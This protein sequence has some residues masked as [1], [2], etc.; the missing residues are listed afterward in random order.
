MSFTLCTPGGLERTQEASQSQPLPQGQDQV[1]G[2]AP[3]KGGPQQFNSA[4]QITLCILCSCINAAARLCAVLL[5]L[6]SQEP[7]T[8]KK[9]RLVKLHRD[10]VR[11]VVLSFL[12]KEGK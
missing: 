12:N 6:G 2:V 3:L 5:S 7:R 8:G 1:G 4:Q 10:L 11:D 9:T